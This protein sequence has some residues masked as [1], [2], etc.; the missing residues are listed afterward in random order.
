MEEKNGVFWL[1]NF[2]GN[3]FRYDTH[4][5]T[6]RSFSLPASVHPVGY[7]T[8]RCMFI[9]SRQRLWL[10]TFGKGLFVFDLKTESLSSHYHQPQQ[11]TPADSSISHNEIWSI[12]QDAQERIWIGTSDGLNLY[13]PERDGFTRF[14]SDYVN[15]IHEDKDGR[16]WFGSP[17]GLHTFRPEHPQS[18]H[19]AYTT[20][21][22]LSND[23]VLS[24]LEDA[25]GYFW[26]GTDYGLSRFDRKRELFRNFDS[27][28]GLLDY[29]FHSG[30]FSRGDDGKMLFAGANGIS[31]ADPSR[32]DTPPSIPEVRLTS[33]LKYEQP[34]HFDKPMAEMDT[35]E[36]AHT[37]DFFT[38][39]FA[40]LDYYRPADNRFAYRLEG[41]DRDWIAGGNHN[42]ATYTNLNPGSYTF[43]VMGAGSDGIWNREGARCTIRIV[44]PW[45]DATWF[46]IV[47]VAAV[48]LF[49]FAV[50]Q[51]RVWVLKQSQ[52]RLKKLVAE[53]TR[54]LAERND[55]LDRLA[56]MDGLTRI[57]N[58]RYFDQIMAREWKRLARDKK[59]LSLLFID[60]DYF[61]QYNDQY[62]HQAGDEC[63]KQIGKVLHEQARRPADLAA[64]YGGEE[65]VVLLPDTDAHGA[66]TI[67]DSV[68]TS[69]LKCR[70]PHE[71]SPVADCLTCSI[72]VAT[73]IPSG[74]MPLGEF[75]AEADQ[76]LYQAKSQGR[77]RV[78]PAA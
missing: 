28:D 25:K 27:R 74:T 73:A 70:I 42:R 38:L 51:W 58:R 72:G 56:N 23:M 43:H 2:N 32:I 39:E 66:R 59:P 13:H 63:L 30:V 9:D 54:E 34:V 22:G 35:I 53:R 44:P 62:G 45:W 10:G 69:L 6:F 12:F 7:T 19:R 21:D 37:D 67:A 57:A 33:F 16:I 76:A 15:D 49:L 78:H 29:T 24:V 71:A 40:V 65:F 61:K 50:Y 68:R 47:A 60:L 4:S 20:A 14:C 48:A 77:N 11:G 55:E 26:L 46:R 31:V 1:G 41:F 64:R 36:L 5:G 17:T 18:T 75:I 3:F 8:I 52:K